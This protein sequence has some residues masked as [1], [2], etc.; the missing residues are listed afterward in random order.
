MKAPKGYFR[1][2]GL[3]YQL[4]QIPSQDALLQHPRLGAAWEGFVIK[5]L[6]VITPAER[7]YRLHERAQVLQQRG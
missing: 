5:Q 1:D 3:L 7:S 6:L 4:L 2:S